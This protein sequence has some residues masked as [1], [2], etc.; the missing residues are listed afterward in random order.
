MNYY[1]LLKIIVPFEKLTHCIESLTELKQ[2]K[3]KTSL[4][5]DHLQ[6]LRF[7]RSLSN[8]SLL[9][10]YLTQPCI[11]YHMQEELWKN[12][13]IRRPEVGWRRNVWPSSAFYIH[14]LLLGGIL[15][16]VVD[17]YSG[18]S[19]CQD[20]KDRVVSKNLFILVS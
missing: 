14:I 10:M 16:A 20:V 13:S 15:F 7:I 2:E 19:Y 3:S 1:F 9:S 12:L 8:G 11:F 4:P 17:F 6:I 18:I 5:G